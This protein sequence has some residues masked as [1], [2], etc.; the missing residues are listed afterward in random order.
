MRL[1]IERKAAGLPSLPGPHPEL[2]NKGLAMAEDRA[3]QSWF[4]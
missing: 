3:D 1:A 4:S 2:G